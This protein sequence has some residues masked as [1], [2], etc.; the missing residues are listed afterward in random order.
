M[1]LKLITF[2]TIIE[3]L[4]INLIILNIDY[5]FYNKQKIHDA[6]IMKYFLFFWEV[7]I[8]TQLPIESLK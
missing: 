1:T 3:A 8:I 6:F 7:K 2:L 5:T 4:N